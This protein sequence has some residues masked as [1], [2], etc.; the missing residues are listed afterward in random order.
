MLG[1]K[2][3]DACRIPEDRPE[4]RILAPA[5]LG[6]DLDIRSI[7]QRTL[8]TYLELEGFLRADTPFYAGYDF[9]PLKRSQEILGNFQGERREFLASLFRMAR[10][11]R[12]WFGI[13]LEKASAELGE[14]RERLVSA[15]DYLAD[16][17]WMRVKASQ[18][19]HRYRVLHRPAELDALADELHRRCLALESREM[20]RV[21]QVLELSQY[22]GCRWNALCDHFGEERLHPCGHCSYCL[23]GEP[24]PLPEPE[25]VE[26]DDG[27]WQ[28][29]L[30]LRRE[31]SD[32]LGAP[33][34]LARFL[35][36]LTSPRLGRARLSSHAL[37]G[38]LSRVPFTEVLERVQAEG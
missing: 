19:R 21:D 15:L 23:D 25:K 2:T 7:V 32:I 28:R 16:Q 4:E 13:D 35:V 11:K 22:H 8:L 14:P 37:F 5:T 6:H 27:L 9:E 18:L 29:A 34:A 24:P 26:I 38:S 36:G 33:R 31:R 17:G 30:E 20:E 1:E 12:K 10:K 3:S